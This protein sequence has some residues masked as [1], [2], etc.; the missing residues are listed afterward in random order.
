MWDSNIDTN[1]KKILLDSVGEGKG[2]VIWEY[3][4]ET[5]ILSYVTDRQLG[6]DSW[7]KVLRAGPLGWGDRG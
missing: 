6:I 4:I 7:D 3:S 2:W 1:V 5:C